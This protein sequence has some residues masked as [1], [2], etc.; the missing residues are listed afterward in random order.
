MEASIVVRI[1]NPVREAVTLDKC[2]KHETCVT[3]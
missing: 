1:G 3:G 2:W